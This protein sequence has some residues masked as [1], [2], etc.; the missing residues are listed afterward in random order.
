MGVFG[1]RGGGA[2]QAGSKDNLGS[3]VLGCVSSG[4]AT[5]EPPTPKK[6][7]ATSGR[8]KARSGEEK[9]FVRMWKLINFT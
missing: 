5:G 6:R 2:A 8:R 1:R 9:S 3:F 7:E 4:A